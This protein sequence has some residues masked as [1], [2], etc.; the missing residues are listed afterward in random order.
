VYPLQPFS[1]VYFE[2]GALLTTYAQE[3][4]N[5]QAESGTPSAVAPMPKLEALQT[6][7]GKPVIT[8]AQLARFLRRPVGAF[9]KERLQVHLEDERSELHDEE[10]FGLAGLDLYQLLDHELTHVPADLNRQNVPAHVQQ[11]V[12]SLRKAGALPLA[13]VGALEA[14]NLASSLETMLDAAIREREDFPD[15]ADRLLID[16]PE[17]D[18]HLQDALGGI[19]VGEQGALSLHMRAS[20]LADLK[21]KKPQALPDK[22]IDVWLISL[23]AAAMGHALTIAVV[24]RNAVVRVAPQAPDA[25]RAQLQQLLV[26][27]ADGMRWPLP[28]PPETALQW[29]KAQGNDNAL[30]DVYEGGHFKR[31]ERSKDPALAR[32]YPTLDALLAG[33]AFERLAEQV[34]APLRDWAQACQVEPLQGTQDVSDEEDMA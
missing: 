33:G 17:A 20:H 16:V 5:A 13:G 8:L 14:Q 26:T 23:A 24:G 34:Y 30:L 15:V 4:R 3:W 27:W 9:F 18:V 1:R 31:A 12:H 21:S 25:A 11:V 2:E 29:L 28:L 19:S 32:T 10:L 22:L 6:A 7:T